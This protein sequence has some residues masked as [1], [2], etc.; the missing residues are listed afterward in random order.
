MIQRKY[1]SGFSLYVQ[2][3][4]NTTCIKLNMNCW[5]ILSLFYMYNLISSS[6][7]LQAIND[8]IY[9]DNVVHKILIST[10]F[11]F[12][13]Y[14]SMPIKP[15]LTYLQDQIHSILIKYSFYCI[16][17]W[18]KHVHVCMYSI[19]MN[20]QSAMLMCTTLPKAS[21]QFLFTCLFNKHNNNTVILSWSKFWQILNDSHLK[22]LKHLQ[23]KMT[24][25]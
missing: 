14:F 16:Q 10:K 20:I 13:M 11:M 19:Y 8:G 6:S 4:P 9:L 1:K 18:Y 7:I 25:C 2:S 24:Y 17:Y 12:Y 3:T 5:T 21:D 15:K 23:K 22:I